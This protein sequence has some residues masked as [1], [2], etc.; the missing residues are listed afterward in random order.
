MPDRGWYRVGVHLESPVL[1]SPRTTWYPGVLSAALS[2]MAGIDGDCAPT[3]APVPH[4]GA[5]TVP[6]CLLVSSFSL[7][8]AEREKI[9]PSDASKDEKTCDE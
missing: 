6:R 8:M 1:G 2:G 9:T 3:L 4:R 7:A 5:Q